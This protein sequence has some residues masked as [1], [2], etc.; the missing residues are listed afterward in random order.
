MKNKELRKTQMR[1]I[2]TYAMDVDPRGF[3]EKMCDLIKEAQGF[4]PV[5]RCRTSGLGDGVFHFEF[6]EVSDK[7]IAALDLGSD[8]VTRTDNGSWG[9]NHI[10]ADFNK[11]LV[12]DGLYRSEA[13][14]LVDMLNKHEEKIAKILND[15]YEPSRFYITELYLHKRTQ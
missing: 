15:A 8:W 12:K 2:T 5:A 13:Q 10:D 14:E 4:A 6:Q 1:I 9:I 3:L 7:A 11:T